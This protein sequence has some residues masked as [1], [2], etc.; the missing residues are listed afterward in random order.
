MLPLLSSARRPRLLPPDQRQEQL[1]AVQLDRQAADLLA[2]E[3]DRDVD[4]ADVAVA[5]LVGRGRGCDPGARQ[6]DSTSEEQAQLDDLPWLQ[7]IRRRVALVG[8]ELDLPVWI[9][10]I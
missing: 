7:H 8:Q 5:I 9:D 6:R 3:R 4:P 10:T 2:V 1:R